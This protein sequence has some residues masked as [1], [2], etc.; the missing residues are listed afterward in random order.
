MS[1][2]NQKK[3]T[4]DS[5]LNSLEALTES[6]IEKMAQATE[7]PELFKRIIKDLKEN[8]KSKEFSLTI[9]TDINT[10]LKMSDATIKKIASSTKQPDIVYQLFKELKEAAKKDKKDKVADGHIFW[11]W[12]YR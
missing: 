5:D 10:I 6:T 3:I 8:F 2:T 12:S 1:N 7:N 11:S 4:I 9:D